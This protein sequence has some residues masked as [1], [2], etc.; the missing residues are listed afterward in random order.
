MISTGIQL[1]NVIPFAPGFESG[2]Y[3][4]LF[5][6]TSS[7]TTSHIITVDENP[8]MVEAF[9]LV[10]SE[11][12]EIWSVGGTGSGQWFSPLY[13]H[14]NK[15]QLTATDNKIS[16]DAS[17]RYQFRLTAGGLGTVFVVGHDANVASN[18]VGLGKYVVG[19]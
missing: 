13:I 18:L 17:G 2:S 9:G 15:A 14:G 5:D 11:V 7:S 1:G 19:E 3:N 4:I 8:F 12:V 16:I 10:D 6:T